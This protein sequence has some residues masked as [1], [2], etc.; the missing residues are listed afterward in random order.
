MSPRT[1]R[2]H[3]PAAGDQPASHIIGDPPPGEVYPLQRGGRAAVPDRSREP[4]IGAACY[5]TDT[6]APAASVNPDT[7]AGP[8]VGPTE[9]AGT[10][11]E[12]GDAVREAAVSHP[13][14]EPRPARMT[15]ATH[16]TVELPTEKGYGP[17]ARRWPRVTGPR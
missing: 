12:H 15:G 10:G 17:V 14:G 13:S 5:D 6:V 8:S 16:R 9:N 2:P 1:P 7:N 4:R 11:Q 3:R